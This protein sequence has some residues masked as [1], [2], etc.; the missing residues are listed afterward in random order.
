MYPSKHSL[1]PGSQHKWKLCNEKVAPTEHFTHLGINR[2]AG[3]LSHEVLMNTRLQLARNIRYALMGA[4]LHGS[5]GISTA[6]AWS[7]YS[8]LFKLGL[9][10]L[11]VKNFSSKSWFVY[12]ARIAGRYDLPSLH[13]LIDSN[14]S[15]RR[16]RYLVK[17]TIQKHW[18]ETLLH[19]AA[20]KAASGLRHVHVPSLRLGTIH[21]VWHYVKSQMRDIN[22][23]RIKAKRDSTPV[24]QSEPEYTE[25]FI[26]SCPAHA[27]VRQTLLPQL[28]S[29][30]PTNIWKN[31]ASEPA[32]FISCILDLNAACHMHLINKDQDT[33]HT[34]LC[35]TYTNR[36]KL[37][38]VRATSTAS[39]PDDT[40]CASP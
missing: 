6:V 2:S 39:A 7:M 23:G 20:S 32:A 21:P 37:L 13:A 40:G 26:L 12:A 22:R 5:N 29:E 27:A 9:R 30:V 25:H 31:L 34:L 15:E 4:G 10:Q 24:C 19:D 8:L 38:E 36:S 17:S 11:S 16:W 35:P 14:I 18:Q 3:K 28:Q 1:T 33:L